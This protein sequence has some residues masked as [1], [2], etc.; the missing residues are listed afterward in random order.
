MDLGLVG[1]HRPPGEVQG[2]RFDDKWTLRWDAERSAGIYNLYRASL[3]TLS[4][5]LSYGGCQQQNIALTTTTDSDPV[6][7]SDGF[8][9]LITVENRLTE[10]GTR[11]HDSDGLERTGSVCP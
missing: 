11:G 7:L 6:P 10:E 2:L 9:Y 1:V 5:G 4:P 8:F 3:G